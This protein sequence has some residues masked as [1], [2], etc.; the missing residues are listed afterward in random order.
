MRLALGEVGNE[1]LVL[2]RTED[3]QDSGVGEIVIEIV[4]YFGDGP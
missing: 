2:E 1:A 3:R 4:A